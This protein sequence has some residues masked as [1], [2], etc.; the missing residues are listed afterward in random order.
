MVDRMK[1]VTSQYGFSEI[2]AQQLK[3][4]GDKVANWLDEV[5]EEFY[6]VLAERDDFHH[7]FPNEGILAHAKEKQ[8]QHWLRLLSG[9]FDEEYAQSAERIG[10]VHFFKIDLPL[11]HYMSGYASVTAHLQ[12]LFLKNASMWGG[13]RQ[14]KKLGQE[15]GLLVRAF[16]LDMNLV[17]ESFFKAQQEEQQRAFKYLRDG[18]A[19]MASKDLSQDI[20]DAGESDYPARFN[21]LRVAFNSLQS[22]MGAVIRTIKNATNDLDLTAAEVNSGADDLAHRTETQAATLEQTSVSVEAIT[23][24]V[25]SS[26]D[27][28]QA[29]DDMMS[30]THQ[31]AKR[32][33]DVMAETVA[34]MKE[35][36]DSS[37]QISQI[38]GVIDDI[39]FQTNLLALNAGVEAARAGDA[40][41]GFAVV[42]HEVRGLAQRAADSANEISELIKASAD[43]V[44][45]GVTLVDQAGDVLGDIVQKVEKVATLTSQVANSSREQSEGLGRI[46]SGLSQLDNVTQQNAAMVEQTAAAV[47]SM[48]RD[49]SQMATLVRDFALD[50][51]EET[52]DI[53]LFSSSRAA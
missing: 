38:T 2:E 50:E 36:A 23:K 11:E 24:S 28:T 52:G 14:K 29:T 25:R 20:P 12:S 10:K 46:S 32:G 37:M 19:R 34:K 9:R 16:F 53:Q 1:T 42:A 3:V 44:E 40:G 15:L 47:G 5:L 51:I 18:M 48:Q 39:A 31:N 43:L 35:I 27:A 33:Q 4:L 26:S 45:S 7:Y 41:R 6:G 21:E 30:Q 22:D 49:T 8:K 17:I 13:S